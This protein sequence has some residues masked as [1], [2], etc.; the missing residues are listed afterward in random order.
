[1]TLSLTDDEHFP[2]R[3]GPSVQA[4][5]LLR[6]PLTKAPPAADAGVGP[7]VSS[8]VAGIWTLSSDLPSALRRPFDT[9]FRAGEDG[10]LVRLEEVRSG[11][12]IRVAP[13]ILGV[14]VLY[15]VTAIFARVTEAP[16]HYRNAH[17]AGP[18]VYDWR[19]A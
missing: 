18:W 5:D 7:V 8:D 6:I 9:Y 10:P 11:S 12:V 19:E 4:G 13:A 1:M 17:F 14:G 15:H 16:P 3:G 2:T